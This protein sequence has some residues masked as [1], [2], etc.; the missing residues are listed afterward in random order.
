MSQGFTLPAETWDSIFPFYILL[1]QELTLLEAGSVLLKTHPFLQ[2]GDSFFQHFK[3]KRPP[4]LQPNFKNLCQL[5]NHILV[6]ESFSSPMLLRTQVLQL[7]EPER[8]LL[9]ASPWFTEAEELKK[10]GITLQDLPKHHPAWDFLTLLQIQRSALRDAKELASLL[11]SQ[12]KGLKEINQKLL[13]Q[14][15]EARKL[16][17][18]AA[19]TENLVILTDNQAQIEWVNPAFERLTGYQL[20][21]V[22]GK[23]PG[24]FLQGP[25]TDLETVGSMSRQLQA[26]MPFSA[27]LINYT[28]MGSKY[29]V[30]IEVRPVHDEQ[31]KIIHFM[32]LES[33]ITQR[34]Q[35]EEELARYSRALQR[36]QGLSTELEKSLEDKIR[37]ILEIGLETFGLEMGILSQIQKNEYRVCY[38]QA[39]PE[40]PSIAEGSLFEL[41]RTYCQKVVKDKKPYFFAQDS[42]SAYRQHPCY[43]DTGLNGYIGSP[44][45]IGPQIFGTLNFSAKIASRPLT[46]RDA[47]IISLFSRWIGFELL[48]NQDLIELANAKE[49]AESSNQMK[50]EFIASISHEIRTPLNAIV[51][52]SELMQ[53][54]VLNAEQKEFM[55]TIWSGSQSLLHLIND[56]L[57]VSK[58]EAGQVDIET[59]EFDPLQ[60]GSQ[61]LQI[62]QSR[63]QSKKLD[64]WF[65]CTPSPAPLVLGDPNRIRQILL[66]LIT[67]A[68]KFTDQG[69]VI[70]RLKWKASPENSIQLSF[71]VED[72]GIGIPPKSQ[73]LIF[74]KFTQVHEH[75]R[76]MGGLGM[77][78]NI[79]L[80]LATAMGGAL[81]FDSEPNQGSIFRFEITL[82]LLKAAEPINSSALPEIQIIASTPRKALI[83]ASLEAWGLKT[84]IHAENP[85]PKPTQIMVLDLSLP[86]EIIDKQLQKLGLSH[87]KGMLLSDPKSE[88]KHEELLSAQNLHWI[89]PPFIPEDVAEFFQFNAKPETGKTIEPHLGSEHPKF[90]KSPHILLVED[91][92][93]NQLLA[94]RWLELEGYRTTSALNGIEA[95]QAYQEMNFE[96]ILMDIQMPKMNGLDASQKI[97]E[98]EAQSGRQ[99]T[100]IIAF[101]AH[102][103]AHYRKEAFEMGM[104]DYMTKPIRRERLVSILNKWIDTQIH[105]LVIDDD[106][107]NHTLIE[108]YL[109]G[110]NNL[111]IE[112]ALTAA[113]GAKMLEK[114]AFSL[115]LLDMEMPGKNGYHFARELK[116]IKKFQQLPI[117]AIT[118]H[119]G[120]NERQKCLEAG[121]SE[122]LEK[123]FSK[124]ELLE[125]MRQILSPPLPSN[126]KKQ[127]IVDPEIADLI[128][129]FIE[130]IL[131]QIQNL[132]PNLI[133]REWRPLMRF[134]HSL[135]GSGASFGFQSV[136]DW[137]ARLETAALQENFASYS[138]HF[139]ALEN[140]LKQ[141]DWAPGETQVLE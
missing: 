84:Q 135:K 17:L 129:I 89:H 88:S 14:E 133:N 3:I 41:E 6:L 24:N 59:I 125:R 115:I 12:Q 141:V 49:K 25:E 110:Q 92:P 136:S 20:D 71:E 108:A 22:K 116:Q 31:G 72:T 26:G 45:Y 80:L 102:A 61:T 58:I 62:L 48:R 47:E 93:E 106:P 78:L 1:D 65:I 67:N 96:L 130:N 87:T 66:N 95:I 30:S 94:K 69:S 86:T 33:D 56:L 23:K 126:E 38:F 119:R 114:K 82:P 107:L 57:D 37:G 121:A 50:T 120:E 19:H 118:G 53:E 51:G 40:I 127:I 74:E 128:P 139:K 85:E 138:E 73:S 109:R 13:S 21:E 5:L 35:A 75:S 54:T 11:Q 60:I 29:W 68:I 140:F 101:T 100:P 7:H 27:E 39:K 97:R 77:G 105:I 15:A 79:S 42:Q 16:A 70:L 124:T 131:K 9:L 111:A 117:L 52:M 43:R 32:A 112:K 2:I 103:V 46:E 18:I 55:S 81:S 123:P 4:G 132:E 36:L 137:G 34:K 134:G 8:L 90:Q 113:Q 91:N 99:R 63:A 76:K 98:L 64:F 44:V 28:K 10:M 122:F 104:D 83:Q